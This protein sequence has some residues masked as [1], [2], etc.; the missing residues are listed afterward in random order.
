[1]SAKL[2]RTL[3]RSIADLAAILEQGVQS[4]SAV[5]EYAVCVAGP[6]YTSALAK[7][8]HYVHYGLVDYEAHCEDCQRI[9]YPWCSWLRKVPCHRYPRGCLCRGGLRGP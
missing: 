3:R 2:R 9:D 5:C 7:R 1:M 6:Q 4:G 8:M